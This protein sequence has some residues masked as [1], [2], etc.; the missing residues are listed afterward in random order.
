MKDCIFCAIGEGTAPA[1]FVHREERVIAFMDLRPA[2]RGHVLVVPTRHWA[3]LSDVPVE[4]AEAVMR[5]AVDISR[6]A[7][8]ALEAA[9]VNFVVASGN[10]AW[11]TV[12]H[13]HLHVVPRY[14]GDGLMPPGPLDQPLGDEREIRAAARRIRGA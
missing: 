1:E 8:A 7:A 6:R 2:T 5:V 14:D 10:A 12:D 9:G 11:Q 4:D 3:D 13:F